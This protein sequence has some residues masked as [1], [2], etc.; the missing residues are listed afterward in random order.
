MSVRFISIMYSVHSS[1]KPFWTH[2]SVPFVSPGLCVLSPP[3]RKSLRGRLCGVIECKWIPGLQPLQNLLFQSYHMINT[4]DV[5]L[6]CNGFYPE[7]HVIDP[8]S[9]EILFSLTSKVQSNWISALCILRPI[10]RQ[11]NKQFPLTLMFHSLYTA[12][13]RC[14]LQ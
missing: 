4:R 10:N 5:R 3:S 14:L 12:Q 9:L 13:S 1:S 6:V 7:I 2:P 11:G 8:F